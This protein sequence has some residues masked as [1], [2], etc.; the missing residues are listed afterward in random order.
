[1]R[2]KARSEFATACGRQGKKGKRGKPK[3]QRSSKVAAAE[4]GGRWTSLECV[5]ED[6][7][8]F[9]ARTLP[10]YCI[11]YCTYLS[12][13]VSLRMWLGMGAS[14][15]GWVDGSGSGDGRVSFPCSQSVS[16]VQRCAGTATRATR[17]SNCY[18]TRANIRRGGGTATQET[19]W[20]PDGRKESSGR[21]RSQS[22]VQC[23]LPDVQEPPVPG[24]FRISASS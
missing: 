21:R 14:A 2:R 10:R 18:F 9:A 1:M 15:S 12:R 20:S 13:T 16:P 6:E 24:D 8:D 3:Q 17:A 7:E 22:R 5:S 23:P 11:A 19:G 4:V